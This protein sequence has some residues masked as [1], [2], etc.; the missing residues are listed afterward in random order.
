MNNFEQLPLRDIH[1][2]DAVFWWPPA[3]GWWL[4]LVAIILVAIGIWLGA[5]PLRA[6]RR[7][8]KLCQLVETEIN[9]IETEYQTAQNSHMALQD[10][11]ILMRRVAVS[12][13]DRSRTAGLCG[14]EWSDWL[15][16]SFAPAGSETESVR[17]LV[18]GPYSKDV[19]A[20]LSLLFLHCR[21]WLRSIT[22]KGDILT[23]C[24]DSRWEAR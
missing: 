12:L 21:K 22:Q 1:L 23:S 19:S 3:I 9:R 11:S 10:L 8:K 20:D 5:R 17:L 24:V 7:R 15:K 16:S 2:P 18:D 6:R 14:R 13:N 4:L